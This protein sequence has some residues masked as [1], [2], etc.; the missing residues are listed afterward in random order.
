[1]II[2][3][4]H[5]S[6]LMKPM[7]LF[8]WQLIRWGEDD[9][10]LKKQSRRACKLIG[11]GFL[12]SNTAEPRGPGLQQEILG[13]MTLHLRIQISSK[14]HIFRKYITDS[15]YSSEFLLV[16]LNCSPHCSIWNEFSFVT[17]FN[18]ETWK[19][20][21]EG[22]INQHCKF[23][24]FLLVLDLFSWVEPYNTIPFWA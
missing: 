22:K 23:C 16:Y 10:T 7:K 15:L 19:G 18:T 9:C 17:A 21:E 14:A 3:I 24:W 20:F 11:E 5:H 8:T 1:M 12:P 2:V 6:C 4:G 13:N